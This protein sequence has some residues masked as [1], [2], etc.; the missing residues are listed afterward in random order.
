MVSKFHLTVMMC[1]NI[2][3]VMMCF[4][5]T[6]VMMCFGFDIESLKLFYATNICD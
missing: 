6:V 2:T 3:N 1:L 5:I 4:Y